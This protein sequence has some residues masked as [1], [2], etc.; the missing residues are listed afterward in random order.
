[1]PAWP[2]VSTPQKKGGGSYLHPK[3]TLTLI[4]KDE[5]TITLHLAGPPRAEHEQTGTLA[6]PRSSEHEGVMGED[7]DC[8]G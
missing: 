1:M 7:E 2:T 6:Q 4:P 5:E 8:W 3:K